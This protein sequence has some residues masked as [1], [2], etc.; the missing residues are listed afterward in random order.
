[1]TDP[2]MRRGRCLCGRILVTIPASKVEVGVC[3]CDT[4]RHWCSGPWMAVQAPDATVEGDT[5]EVF[6]S[7]PFAERGF[8]ARCGSAI[9]HRPQDGPELA[10][11]AGLF[12]PDDFS[13][14]FQICTDRKPAFYTI[15]EKTAVMTSRQLALR[16]APKLLARRLLKIARLRD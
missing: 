9:F 7:S 11:S 14:S 6:R 8:C 10:V 15:S 12:K 5:L 3:H 13:L 2:K 16:W 4:C 1:M